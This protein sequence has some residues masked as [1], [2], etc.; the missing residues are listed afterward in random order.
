MRKKTFRAAL[1]FRLQKPFF[2]KV[3]APA[4]SSYDTDYSVANV[5]LVRSHSVFFSQRILH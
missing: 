4:P 3:G 1:F 2:R 5:S